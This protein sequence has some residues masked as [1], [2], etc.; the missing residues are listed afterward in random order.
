ML[1]SHQNNGE[2]GSRLFSYLKVKAAY[3]QEVIF[4]SLTMFQIQ[5]LTLCTLLRL[6][7]WVAHGSW[8]F[9]EEPSPVGWDSLLR[10]HSSLTAL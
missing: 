5:I 10:L 7:K 2:M 4:E 6:T 9:S 8:S 1:N 3:P